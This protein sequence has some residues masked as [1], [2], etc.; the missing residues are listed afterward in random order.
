MEEHV[1]LFDAQGVV[2]EVF[3]ALVLHVE[4]VFEFFQ[5]H[6]VDEVHLFLLVRLG[7][8]ECLAAWIQCLV[9]LGELILLS[10]FDVVPD[11][12]EADVV[13]DWVQLVI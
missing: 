10:G 5:V 13:V 9:F 8:L 7:I 2:L 1:A 3:L 11:V 4:E 12:V 6:F